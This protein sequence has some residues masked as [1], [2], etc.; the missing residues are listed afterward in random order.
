MSKTFRNLQN[1][2]TDAQS[3]L[4]NLEIRTQECYYAKYFERFLAVKPNNKVIR[5]SLKLRINRTVKQISVV[6]VAACSTQTLLRDAT[7]QLS[8]LQLTLP[9][10]RSHF[11]INFSRLAM[12]FFRWQKAMLYNVSNTSS[13][14]HC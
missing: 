3:Q 11:A 2:S 14:E 12:I 7:M 1:L 4:R 10:I 13:F 8:P 6:G 9:V 5:P